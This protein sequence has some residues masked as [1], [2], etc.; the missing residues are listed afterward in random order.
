MSYAPQRAD[1]MLLHSLRR[2]TFPEIDRNR[3]LSDKNLP[4]GRDWPALS[5]RPSRP[6][7]VSKRAAVATKSAIVT[8]ARR[9]AAALLAATLCLYAGLSQAAET[10]TPPAMP[11]MAPPPAGQYQL[12]RALPLS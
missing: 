2:S 7:A 1:F 4:R 10:A 12:L 3:R 6:A 5:P 11:P 8:T 9:G